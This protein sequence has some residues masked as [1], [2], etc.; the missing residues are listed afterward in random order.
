[1]SRGRLTL[2]GV[3]VAVLVGCASAPPPSAGPEG[4]PP[5][6]TSEAASPRAT[7][8]QR[9][10]RNGIVPVLVGD[11][12]DLASLSGRIV[13]DDF[14][15]V[16]TMNADGTG[17]ATVAGA[18]G[19]EFDGTWS[20]DGAFIAYRD[21][22]R[23]INEDDEIYI[24]AA[25]GSG[26]RNLT[27]DPANDWGPE[28]SPYGQWIA[29]NS[30]RDGTPLTGYLVRPDGSEL[31]RIDVDAWF[32][33]P[34]FSPDGRHLVFEGHA[35]SDYDVYTV[36]VETG[37]TTQ[38]TDSP[39]HDGWAVWSPDGSTIAFA[40]ERD[41]CARTAP[42][43]DCWYGDGEPGEHHDIWLMDADGGSQ[44]R[45]TP[46]A[47]HFVAWSPDGEYLLVSG[48]TLFAIRPDGTGR[49]EIRPPELTYA[50]GGIPDWVR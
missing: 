42:G 29:F 11:P 5:S 47:G 18:P 44:R 34:S 32:E 4:T 12:I 39:G 24:V 7:P 3:T 33:Y 25:D 27:Q 1:M 2:A 31:H 50:P 48:R 46:E 13:F 41:D 6:A 17:F 16:Y 45:V 30:D 23:G 22:R 20:P 9:T 37:L 40:T 8:A 35:G 28:W 21:S 10:E 14:E 38:L 36:E 43:A 19:S 26:A 49:V 15:D